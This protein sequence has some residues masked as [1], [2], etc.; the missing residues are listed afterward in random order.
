MSLSRYKRGME[1]VDKNWIKERI[2]GRRGVQAEL[3]EAAGLTKDQLSK[4]L[5]GTRKV[6]ADEVP[7]IIAFFEPRLRPDRAEILSAIAALPADLAEQAA[8][9]VR[10]LQD[11]A[12]K[13]AEQSTHHPT[14]DQSDQPSHD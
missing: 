6:Q 2:A 4:I 1:V 8:A 9:H 11:L 12:R 3:A 14:T 5:A 10:Y 13:R 7:R